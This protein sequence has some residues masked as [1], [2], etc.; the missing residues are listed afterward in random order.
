MSIKKG[1]GDYESLSFKN[2]TGHESQYKWMEANFNKGYKLDHA[3]VLNYQQIFLSSYSLG[4]HPDFDDMIRRIPHY[5]ERAQKEYENL[6]EVYE[7]I[8]QRSD[9]EAVAALDQLIDEFKANIKRIIQKQD[10]K[11]LQKFIDRAEQ[12]AK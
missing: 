12:L 10:K 7:I 4:S 9:P 6:P 1:G 11:A 8:K 5:L 3:A 2:I